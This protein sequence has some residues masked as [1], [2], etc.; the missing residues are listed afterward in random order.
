MARKLK[1]VDEVEGLERYLNLSRGTLRNIPSYALG[2]AVEAIDNVR[3]MEQNSLFRPGLY[4]IVLTDL[5]GNTAF[6]AKYGNEEGDRRVQWFHTAVIQ[7]IGQIDL[8]NYVAFSK[9]VGD[10]SL[11]I[12]SAFEDV[13]NWSEKFTGNLDRLSGEYEYII[14]DGGEVPRKDRARVKAFG[15]K[16][17]RLVHLGEVA[18]K[19][20]INPLSLA[21]SQTFK[22]EKHFSETVLGCTQ[23]V[24]DAV[25]PKLAEL[26][27]H[28]K[29]NKSVSIPGFEKSMTYYVR[30]KSTQGSTDLSDV[31]ALIKARYGKKSKK[32]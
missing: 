16:A 6:N 8:K 18:Y 15:L 22:I 3:H 2:D 17:R 25:G 29:K 1:S 30:P 32:S 10:A 5:V 20:E 7:S 31:R 28:L 19:D 24:A 21:V 26:D 27:L 9:T 23:A 14:A 13:Y 4:Y 11:L 12:F